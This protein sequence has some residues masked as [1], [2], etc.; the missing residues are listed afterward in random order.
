MIPDA[1]SVE[2]LQQLTGRAR[3]DLEGFAKQLEEKAHTDAGGDSVS[4]KTM[5]ACTCM[6]AHS[7]SLRRF[8]SIAVLVWEIFTI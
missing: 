6:V 2:H 7:Q 8:S 3:A 1:C 4:Q 5:A